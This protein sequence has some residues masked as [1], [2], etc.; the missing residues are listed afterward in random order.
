MNQYSSAL[1]THPSQS[2]GK[3]FLSKRSH[4]RR[5]T[6]STNTAVWEGGGQRSRVCCHRAE[7]SG[8]LHGSD[9]A[10]G[11]VW[12]E[13]SAVWRSPGTVINGTAAAL[14]KLEPRRTRTAQPR[15]H[16]RTACTEHGAPPALQVPH[17]ASPPLSSSFC[18]VSI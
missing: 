15:C 3:K 11:R 12:V 4:T 10:Q 6:C 17:A 9:G 13:P 8:H 1:F 2:E 7:R 18:D 5:P 16:P 14:L